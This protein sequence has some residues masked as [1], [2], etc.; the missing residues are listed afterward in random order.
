[1]N[2]EHPPN[3]SLKPVEL[4]VLQGTSF[5][6]LNCTY[7][8][9]SAESRRKK[10]VMDPHLTGR[11]FTQLFE[12]RRLAPEVMVIWHSGEPL[13][14]PPS[15][16]DEAIGGILSLQEKSGANDTVLTFGIQTNGVLIDDDW[17]RFFK[18]HEKH[19]DLGVSCDG[20][21][22]LHD[23]YRVNW[24]D[25]TT[26]LQT[27]RGMDLLASYGIKY[28]IIAVV[29]GRTLSQPDEFFRFF[30]DRREQLSGFHFNI[31]ADGK[32]P[33]PGLA[34]SA[35]DRSSYYA[36][37]KRLIELNREVQAAGH[38]F[39]IV[40]FSQGISR[41]LALHDE[42]APVFYDQGTAPLKS[43][44]LDAHGNV[45]TFYAGL[46]IDVLPDAYGDGKG[47]SLGNILDTTFEDM[48]ESDK[49]QRI[50]RDFAISRHACQASCEYF[51]VCSGGYEILKKQSFGTFDA[52]ETD[53]CVIHVKTLVDALLDDINHHLESQHDAN[54]LYQ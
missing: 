44:S 13:T 1:M 7:C 28:K 10:T 49:L 52:A 42:G 2:R 45:T 3:D 15:Y 25:R 39:D 22:E 17:C 50:M 46:A 51:S 8:D 19:L 36:F 24:N 27:V 21:N 18:R 14:L 23:L 38:E 20:P 34:Y 32:S 31:V 11:M 40:N 12:S 47:L 4:I 30:F 29:T 5:C 33:H 6:N 35:L 54:P 26:H 53:E 41:I 48:V 43:I 37:Y 16:Y 9:L